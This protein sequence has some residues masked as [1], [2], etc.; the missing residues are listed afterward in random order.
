MPIERQVGSDA[1]AE[2][3]AADLELATAELKILRAERDRLKTGMARLR[4]TE[5]SM[6]GWVRR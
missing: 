2:S 3:L 5:A 4:E 6:I 1:S